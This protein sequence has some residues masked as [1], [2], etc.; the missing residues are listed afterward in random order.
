MNCD[1]ACFETTIESCSDIVIKAGLT[2]STPYYWLIRK[3]SSSKVIQRLSSTNSDGELTI[4]KAELPAGYL[5]RGN[6]YSIEV[7]KGNNYLEPAPLV[8]GAEEYK[9]IIAELV[10]IDRAEDDESRANVIEYSL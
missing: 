4:L 7:R 10:A 9:C 3:P 1:K 8:F 2:A 5:V 6:H